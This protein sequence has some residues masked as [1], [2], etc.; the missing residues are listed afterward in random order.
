[1]HRKSDGFLHSVCPDDPRN[2]D[3]GKHCQR[4]GFETDLDRRSNQGTSQS[5]AYQ[6]NLER[7]VD[8]ANTIQ[9][10]SVEC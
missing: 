4:N 10:T 7:P 2:Y 1:M 8:P 9:N 3:L 6:G 5:Q